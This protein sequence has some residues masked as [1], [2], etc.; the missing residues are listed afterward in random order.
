M[1]NENTFAS[2]HKSFWLRVVPILSQFVKVQNTQLERFYKPFNSTTRDNR[3][4]IAELSFRLFAASYQASCKVAELHEAELQS[5]IKQS[6]DFIHR[7]R[8]Y[9]RQPELEITSEG[10]SEASK[11][12]DRLL[13]FFSS[14]NTSLK[15]WPNFPGCGWLDSIEG[16]LLGGST[17]YEIKCGQSKLRGKDIRQILCYLSLN[18]ASKVYEIKEICIFNPRIGTV[19]RC[20]IETLCLGISGTTGPILLGD[21]VEY[22]SEPNWFLEGV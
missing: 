20:T 4:L 22:I 1:I 11:L 8:A 7:F 19:F 5:C 12:A 9:S 14:E 18:H 2:S 3:G 16:D 15:L 13:G 6:I 17:L 21:I 10:L